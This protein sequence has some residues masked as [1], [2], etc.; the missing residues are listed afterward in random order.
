MCICSLQNYQLQ[1]E[2]DYFIKVEV[3]SSPYFE[4]NIIEMQK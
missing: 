3:V 4:L 1:V 2:K